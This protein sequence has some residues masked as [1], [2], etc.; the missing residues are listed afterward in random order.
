MPQNAAGILTNV[1]SEQVVGNM[2]G[3]PIITDPN[4]FPANTVTFFD[5][6]FL[7]DKIGSDE[8]FFSNILDGTTYDA[9][10]FE[11]SAVEPS[12]VQAIVNQQENALIFK[13][14]CQYSFKPFKPTEQTQ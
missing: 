14:R 1:A 11:T 7:L 12:F 2:Q 10:D 13:Q 6:Y 4:F 5:E 3:L 8:W 9:L